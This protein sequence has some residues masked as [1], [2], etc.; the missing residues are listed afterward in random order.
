MLFVAVATHAA[1]LLNSGGKKS[2]N[3]FQQE[4]IWT[5][6]LHLQET[7]TFKVKSWS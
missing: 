4:I 5:N 1:V 3:S 6:V 2:M 7:A